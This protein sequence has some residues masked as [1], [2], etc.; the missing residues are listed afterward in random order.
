MKTMFNE[1][2]L[3]KAVLVALVTIGLSAC[4]SDY[5]DDSQYQPPAPPPAPAPPPP[6]K[7][8]NV[9]EGTDINSKSHPLLSA[10]PGGPGG[11]PNQSL[12]SGDVLVGAEMDDILIGGL[13]V[14]VL[15]GYE[16]DDIMIGGTED[17]NSSVDGDDRGSDNRDRALGFDGD[18]TFIW[19]PGDGSDYF[20][21]GDGID[22]LIFGILGESRD[23]DGNTV[24]APFFGVNP[25]GS[26]G[27]QDFDGI[28]LDENGQPRVSV[29]GSPGFCSVL[30][31][32]DNQAALEALEA[33]NI[34]RFSLR[35]IA[36]AFD[37]GDRSDDDG[38][39]VAVTA[40]SVEFLVCTTREI[41]ENN[42]ANNI[43]VLDISGATPVVA[44]ISDLPEYVQELIE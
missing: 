40:E 33:D 38:L 26:I 32:D 10:N 1:T 18:D 27:S 25:P 37:A 5:N 43:Q 6:P 13:G 15:L 36:N 31:Q 16:G 4:G 2:K 41:D 7:Q 24:G 35:G 42:S 22:V 23:S 20:D 8:F 39:R 21:G 28:F 44:S 9:V 17:F 19:A 14:D 30:S 3:S 34:V 11:S 12:R 29:S